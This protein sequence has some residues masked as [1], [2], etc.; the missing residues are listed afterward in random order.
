[1]LTDS[2]EAERLLEFKCHRS[3]IC[4]IKSADM[5]RGTPVWM[6]FECNQT[7]FLFL[8]T[9]DDN[10]VFPAGETVTR[11]WMCMT[12]LPVGLLGQTEHVSD[13]S[14]RKGYSCGS[15]LPSCHSALLD[16]IFFGK[17]HTHTHTEAVAALTKTNVT[18]DC[19]SHR[20][21]ERFCEVWSFSK[22]VKHEQ[23]NDSGVLFCFF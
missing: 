23:L 1:M 14:E 12:Q 19:R 10:S 7:S 9:C 8:K 21:L 13:S 4:S 22:L 20:F 15:T 6:F 18:S 16:E 5:E 17:T 11:V 3:F 2:S